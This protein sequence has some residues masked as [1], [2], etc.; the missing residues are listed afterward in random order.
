MIVK[1]YKDIDVVVDTSFV[2]NGKVVCSPVT[3]HFNKRH[4]EYKEINS[5]I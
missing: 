3:R 4:T 1:Q 2:S 5:K